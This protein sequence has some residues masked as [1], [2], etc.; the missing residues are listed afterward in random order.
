M[1]FDSRTS[2]CSPALHRL[3]PERAEEINQGSVHGR[4]Q[5]RWGQV[6]L[7]RPNWH[8]KWKN[9]ENQSNLGSNDKEGQ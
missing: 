5:E 8:R 4:D 1:T 2:P 9:F 7:R 6:G 3:D